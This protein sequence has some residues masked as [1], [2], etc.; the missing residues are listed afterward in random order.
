MGPRMGAKDGQ[1]GPEKTL[2]IGFYQGSTEKHSTPDAAPSTVMKMGVY[3]QEGTA[4]QV[5]LM[6]PPLR[7]VMHA[8]HG[9]GLR[10]IQ[11]SPPRAARV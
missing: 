4:S 2:F 1:W 10:R 9:P 5:T 7:G 6:N 8:A 3:T 11:G